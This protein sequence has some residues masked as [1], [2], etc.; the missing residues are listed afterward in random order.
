M[1]DFRKKMIDYGRTKYPTFDPSDMTDKELNDRLDACAEFIEAGLWRQGMTSHE[2]ISDKT[3]R[4]VAEFQH[5]NTAAFVDM[6]VNAWK[7]GRLTVT[8]QNT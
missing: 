8:P 6:L 4:P 3:D 5:A 7:S 1:V 2:T